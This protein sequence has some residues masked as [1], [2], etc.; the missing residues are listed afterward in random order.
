[1]FEPMSRRRGWLKRKKAVINTAF[2]TLKLYLVKGL[3]H[4]LLF[5]NFIKRFTVDAHGGCRAGF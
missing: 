5:F 1:M 4:L 3:A 2:Y